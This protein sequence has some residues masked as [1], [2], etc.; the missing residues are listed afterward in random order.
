MRTTGLVSTRKEVSTVAV[1]A[2]SM[3]VCVRRS[4]GCVTVPHAGMVLHAQR[5]KTMRTLVNVLVGLQDQTVKRQMCVHHVRVKTT[6]HCKNIMVISTLS[7]MS[8]LLLFRG[9]HSTPH[10][11]VLSW[12]KWPLHFLSWLPLL[13]GFYS[14]PHHAVHL[15]RG[16][17]SSPHN[18]VHPF[19]GFYSI[20]AS[21]FTVE[22][23]LTF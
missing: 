12:L 16:F 6:P 19:R 14:S 23:T 4:M 21:V 8:Q 1:R 13:R 11:A 5:V 3:G 17:Y 22:M 15:F 10:H 9:F 7:G 20:P 2:A 18:A